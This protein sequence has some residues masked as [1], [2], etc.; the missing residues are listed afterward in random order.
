MSETR[1]ILSE[2]IASQESKGTG[3]YKAKNRESSAIGKYQFLWGQWGDDIKKFSGN[4]N[5]TE[6][7]FKN[8]PQLQDSFME[9]Y[10]Q[11]V[12]IPEAE[13][14]QRRHGDKFKEHGIEDLDDAQTLIHYQGYNGATHFLKTGKSKFSKNNKPIKGYIDDAKKQRKLLRERANQLADAGD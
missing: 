12:L 4:P 3:G 13:K 14:L 8:D 9:H 2:G 1:K 10:R 5:L 11:K 7:D 6:D